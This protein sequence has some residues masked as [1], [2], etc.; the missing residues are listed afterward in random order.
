[1]SKETGYSRSCERVWARAEDKTTRKSRRPFNPRTATTAQTSLKV[2][3]VDTSLMPTNEV[4]EEEEPVGGL[5][6]LEW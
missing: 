4:T 1:M 3:P 2:F 6:S 5:L